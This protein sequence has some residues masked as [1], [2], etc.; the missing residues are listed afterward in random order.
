M[1]S[2]LWLITVL[3]VVFWLLGF[4]VDIG[5]WIHFL[6]VVAAV[7]LVFNLISAATRGAAGHSHT[8]HHDI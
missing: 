3:L 6:L 4:A 8:D 2:L 5:A 7:L 1:V